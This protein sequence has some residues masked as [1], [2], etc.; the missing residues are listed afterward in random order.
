MLIRMNAEPLDPSVAFPYLGRTVAYNNR[1]WVDLYQNLK[2]TRRRF[3]V[4][5][6]V[7]KKMV[8]MVR[9]AEGVLQGSISDGA[10][11]W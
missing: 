10:A 7:V 9:V 6:K 4:V 8:S 5:A 1:D 2:K 11:I 3:G